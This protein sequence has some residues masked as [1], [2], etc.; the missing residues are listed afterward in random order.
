MVK[1]PPVQFS[2]NSIEEA[3]TGGREMFGSARASHMALFSGAILGL[4]FGL[5]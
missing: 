1:N 2:D 5:R 4:G 3:P